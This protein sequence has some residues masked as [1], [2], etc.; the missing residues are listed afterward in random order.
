MQIGTEKFIMKRQIQ[1]RKSAISFYELVFLSPIVRSSRSFF[2]VSFRNLYKKL[3]LLVYNENNDESLKGCVEMNL[4][5]K[6]SVQYFYRSP[7]LFTMLVSFFSSLLAGLLSSVIST[8]QN[9]SDFSFEIVGSVM[10]FA[11]SFILP[12]VLTIENII[13]LFTKPKS[14]TLK[15]AI[16]RWEIAALMVGAFFSIIYLSF[17]TILLEDWHVQLYNNQLHSP[18]ATDSFLTIGGIAL[19]AT[20]GYFILR[21]I[22]LQKL[23]PLFAV[24]CMSALYLGIP[25]ASLWCIQILNLFDFRMVLLSLLPFNCILIAIRT[26]R[27][28]V[29]QQ[30]GIPSDTQKP[31]L[32][33]LQNT[34]NW[35]WL[36]FLAAIPLLGIIVAVL[37]LFGQEPDRF[38]KAWTETADWN[39]SQKIAP[40]N[41]IK[42]E[43]YLCTVAAGG[44]Q[45]IVK[46]IRTGKRHG[47]EV[48]V[49]R[50]LSIAN[51]F[52]QLLEERLPRFHR[53][54]RKTYDQLGYPI[55]RHIK[56]PYLADIIYFIMKPLEWI[57]L[58]TLYLFDVK[59][60]NRIAVQYPH[61][62][63]NLFHEGNEK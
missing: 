23:P 43:H 55:A 49:N 18:I 14:D 16:K 41:I 39:M 8:M 10:F 5:F 17:S 19:V 26:I 2:V 21:F 53:V 57:F 11:T 32:R 54:V 25:L 6:K 60:E 24:L 29:Q 50:Q 27:D 52:E 44:H 45:K 20:F 48:I 59:P 40:Q 15:R 42:D 4:F 9:P 51:A 12:V 7:I 33:L 63:P 34:A 1:V 56:S 47:H 58:L 22:P 37:L 3:M 61:S 13:F 38:I 30:V 35:P 28:V 62:D 31:L 46:P 36:A